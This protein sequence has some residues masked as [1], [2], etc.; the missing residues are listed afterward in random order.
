MTCR[1]LRLHHLGEAL[2]DVHTPPAQR[3]Q[4][5]EGRGVEAG[6]SLARY[7]TL[8]YTQ[9]QLLPL[10][11]VE[12]LRDGEEILTMARH[13]P[14]A[15]AGGPAATLIIAATHPLRVTD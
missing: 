8:I 1:S 2:W 10:V 15:T 9:A 14:G 4:G 13:V 5:Q 3:S 12:G 7:A 11:H 6:H